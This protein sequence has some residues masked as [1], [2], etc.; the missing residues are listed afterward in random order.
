[1]RGLL[2]EGVFIVKAEWVMQ[3]NTFCKITNNIDSPDRKVKKLFP[4]SCAGMIWYSK[5]DTALKSLTKRFHDV[6]KYN[7]KF[8]S[9]IINLN[10][11]EWVYMLQIILCW[12]FIWITEAQLRVRGGTIKA[13]LSLSWK[14]TS[15]F[16][17]IFKFNFF[18]DWCSN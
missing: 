15:H 8:F 5:F 11:F 17:V 3:I 10:T 13:V 1:M 4:R 18:N 9:Y 16:P 6:N 14:K 2:F 12:I 7:K